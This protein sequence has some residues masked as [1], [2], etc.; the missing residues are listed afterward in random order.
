ML[1]LYA[2]HDYDIGINVETRLKHKSGSY[3]ADFI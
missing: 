3:S 1:Q 2:E